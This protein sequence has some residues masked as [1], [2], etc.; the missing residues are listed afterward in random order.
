MNA[1]G[2]GVQHSLAEPDLKLTIECE[3]VASCEAADA[4]DTAISRFLTDV[5]VESLLRRT[6]EWKLKGIDPSR[7]SADEIVGAF[8]PS[9]NR[10]MLTAGEIARAEQ[11]S[12][13][14]IDV[15]SAITIYA[16]R[17]WPLCRP[18]PATWVKA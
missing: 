4:H 11:R 5:V 12:V 14:L 8:R 16:C 13:M 10:V 9:L 7:A 15:L 17:V 3:I 1:I 6:G 18:L 2:V